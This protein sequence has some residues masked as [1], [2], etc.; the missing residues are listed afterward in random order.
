MLRNPL[1]SPKLW[2]T[3]RRES[4]GSNPAE[5]TVVVDWRLPLATSG[6]RQ[7]VSPQAEH[8]FDRHPTK[9]FESAPYGRFRQKTHPGLWDSSTDLK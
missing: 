1:K 5:I 2:K 8:F 7:A 3:S 6:R 9:C 4:V